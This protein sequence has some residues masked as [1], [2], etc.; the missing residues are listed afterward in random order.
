MRC[1]FYGESFWVL[2]FIIFSHSN[3]M[4]PVLR[5]RFTTALDTCILR[6]PAFVHVSIKDV[7]V[8]GG[9]S[10][11]EDKENTRNTQRP[12][13]FSDIRLTGLPYDVSRIHWH[14]NWKTVATLWR[15]IKLS[16]RR[17]RCADSK[18]PQ[19][20][21]VFPHH[22]GRSARQT[23]AKLSADRTAVCRY[24]YPGLIELIRMA[25]GEPNVH[26]TMCHGCRASTT[27]LSGR[28]VIRM[29]HTFCWRHWKTY[30]LSLYSV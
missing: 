20:D 27:I 3:A 4:H 26:N 28:I 24:R 7:K 23:M 13:Y 8:I 12:I 14:F 11:T 30:Y 9:T 29:V 2:S 17:C 16:H 10:W 22:A 18:A 1:G 15:P 19:L 25:R 6:S 5:P 21:T